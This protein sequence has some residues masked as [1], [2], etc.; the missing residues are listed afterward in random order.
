MVFSRVMPVISASMAR[1]G[2][3]TRLPPAS[4]SSA[5]YTASAAR[6]SC[7]SRASGR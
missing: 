7:H 4:V 1:V 3:T 6:F 5:S 2:V